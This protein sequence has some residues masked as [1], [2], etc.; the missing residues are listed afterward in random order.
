MS[1]SILEPDNPTWALLFEHLPS[2]QRDIFYAPSFARLCKKTLNSS[3]EVLCAALASESGVVLYPFVKRDLA[4]LTGFREF[5]GMYDITSLYGRGGIVGSP[6]ALAGVTSFYEAMAAYCRQNAIVCGFDRFHPVIA[7]DLCAA[8]DA[9]IMEIGGFVVVDM[10]ADI[11]TIEK[12]FKPSVRK[13]LRKAER[14]GITCFAESDGSHL[15]EFMEI[16]YHTMERNS[17]ADFYY[18][19]EEYFSALQEE[20]P[21]QF[22]FFYTVSR[23][24]IVSCELAL[25]YGKYCHSF[26]GG[27]TKEALPLC[28]N[29]LLK[30]EIIRHL[31]KQG[32]EYFLLGGGTKPDD[33][34]FNFK[35]AYAPEGVRPSRIGGIIWD[36]D[37]Y[38]RLK[39]YMLA[40]GRTVAADR[41]QFYDTN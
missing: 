37:A 26:L 3:D 19:T 21:G 35:K 20:I 16:Y 15:S 4:R 36:Q 30:R 29:P 32:C 13:D 38:A 7:N 23:D 34:I 24:K 27:T 28:A 1:F 6:G 31:K 40:A 33:G 41:F 18:F 25:H 12:S 17:A 22:H 39:E 11:D 10:R 8:S 5:S 2:D 9:K 14:N